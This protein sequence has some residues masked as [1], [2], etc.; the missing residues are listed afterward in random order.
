MTVAVMCTPR[1]ACRLEV[2]R[3]E[4]TFIADP[5]CER[6][7]KVTGCWSRL[8]EVPSLSSS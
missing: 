4:I 3:A 8:A 1:C 7:R 2:I 5:G 6:I